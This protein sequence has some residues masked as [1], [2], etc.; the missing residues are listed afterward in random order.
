[1]PMPLKRGS[2][3]APCSTPY[4][5]V[6]AGTTLKPVPTR[7][8]QCSPGE[9]RLDKI[10]RLT[11]KPKGHTSFST[12]EVVHT[13]GEIAERLQRAPR[14]DAAGPP[15]RFYRLQPSNAE[16]AKE[17]STLFELEDAM[18][19]NKANRQSLVVF[20]GNP[21]DVS[22]DGFAGFVGMLPFRGISVALLTCSDAYPDP[23]HFS[24]PSGCFE[25][26][27]RDP[28]R[29]ATAPIKAIFGRLPSKTLKYSCADWVRH[30]T[31]LTE[32]PRPSPGPAIT[33]PAHLTPPAR[34]H[35]GPGRR[36]TQAVRA[37]D[38]PPV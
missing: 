5:T 27:V 9:I 7:Y 6:P 25:A 24:T 17:Y 20:V 32:R 15:V 18:L 3:C 34:R 28:A 37:H 12:I 31:P 14:I 2:S 30:A 29:M 10:V 11:P 33:R 13:G 22:A 4:D 35:A 36:Q 38:A 1:M 8:H 26:D 23:F 16:P 19:L 21:D